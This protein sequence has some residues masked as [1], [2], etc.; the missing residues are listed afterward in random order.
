MLPEIKDAQDWHHV[1]PVLKTMMRQRPEFMHDYSRL[2]KNIEVKI[3]ELGNID[4]QLRKQYSI[5]YKQLRTD[6][7]RE[8]N[9]T[10]RMFSKMLLI[11][12]LSKR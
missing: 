2:V 5:H 1:E 3:R 9:D 12:T 10:I 4:I 11:S 7:L 8:I 6:K